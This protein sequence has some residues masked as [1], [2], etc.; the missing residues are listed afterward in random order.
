MRPQI[1]LVP[2]YPRPAWDVLFSVPVHITTGMLLVDY[3]ANGSPTPTSWPVAVLSRL[4]EQAR[5]DLQ[6][7]EAILAHGA[8]LRDFV[9]ERVPAKEA[10]H[11]SWPAFHNWL[12]SLSRADL[13]DLVAYSFASGLAWYRRYQAPQEELERWLHSLGTREPDAATIA[14]ILADPERGE[15]AARVLL[16]SWYGTVPH[17]AMDLALHP[18]RLGTVLLRFLDELWA[19]GFRESWDAQ[20]ALLRDAVDA[21]RAELDGGDTRLGSDELVLR[22]TGL[23]PGDEVAD[24]LRRAARI[25]FVPCLHLHHYLTVLE[26][27]GTHYV[28]Y[29]PADVGARRSEPGGAPMAR[30]VRNLEELGAA[31]VAL[32]D[33]TRL[34]ILFLL[35]ERGELVAQQ[36][37]EALGVHQSTVS[38]NLT[39]LER[40]RLVRV[41]REGSLKHYLLQR[42]RIRAICHQLLE[43]IG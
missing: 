12:A 35:G 17:S 27:T 33:A 11:R 3:A 22:V 19:Q 43:A 23:Q 7:V 4:S 34:A 39:Q 18:E 38:R 14:A 5:H 10:P 25:V 9:L 32:G 26:V 21:V 41:R 40:T 28:L 2:A 16:A 42:H 30:E 20:E 8:N 36:I 1:E 6:A 29:E 37:V 13:G 15:A 31:V 24:T